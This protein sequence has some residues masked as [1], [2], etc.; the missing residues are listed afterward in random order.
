MKQSAL[1][2]TFVDDIPERLEDSRLY[3]S[4]RHALAMHLCCCGCRG[5]V[6]TPLSPAEWRL[7]VQDG[8]ATLYP[9]IGNWGFPCRS[10][11]WVRSNRIE[12]ALPMSDLQISEVRERD[13]NDLQRQVAS[14]NAQR[15]ANRPWLARQL[16]AL[17][18]WV[19][20]AFRD[21]G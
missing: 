14:A 4:Q 13:R 19:L 6:V 3:V 1:V 10:H 20:G 17:W 15:D 2:P 16:G 12:W 9:S 5:E 7:T 8:R 11:Y 18:K 21:R